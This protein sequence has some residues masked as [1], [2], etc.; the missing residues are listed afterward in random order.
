ML[1]KALV[2]A[3]IVWP[4]A[5]GGAVWHRASHPDGR[6]GLGAT[7]VYLAGGRICHQRPERS[8]ATRDVQWPV[9]ARC[10]G[11]Y[12]AAPFGALA[13]LARRRTDW[14]ARASARAAR[15]G[16]KPGASDYG[17]HWLQP[18]RLLALAA[19]PTALTLLW[20]WGG[21]GTPS[22]LIRFAT[23]LPLGAAVMWVLLQVAGT[24]ESIG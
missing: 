20:E 7:V 15:P 14:R 5:A 18:V 1:T 19:I 10:S 24:R 22:N 17:A 3:A 21:M 16:L 13:L 9:C 12:L 6:P 8:F 23:A 11:L 4:L 2:A